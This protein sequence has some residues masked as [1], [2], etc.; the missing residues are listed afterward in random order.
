MIQRAPAVAVLLVA[1]GAA[2]APMWW[3]FGTLQLVVSL[4]VVVLVGT[5]IA[6]LAAVRRWSS[7]TIILTGLAALALLAVPLTAPQRI[8]R[9]EWLPA[10][11]D[12]AAA[13]VLSWRRLLTIG[14]PVGTGDS[15]LMAPVVLVLAGTIIGVS[16]ALRSR[17][18]ETAA[19][20][21]AAI[22]VWSILWGPRDL[23]DPW[24]S[25]LLALVPIGAYVAVV[26]QARR[27]VRAPRALSSLAR[28]IVAGS[29][30]AVVAAGAAGVAGALVPLP[31]RTVLRGDSPSSIEL[32][33]A[34][35]LAAYRSFW[36]AETRAAAQLTA[37]G[38]EPGDRIRTAVLESYDGEVLSVGRSP[39]ERVA[40]AEPGRGDVVGVTVDGLASQWLPVVGTPSAIRFVGERAERLAGGLHRNDALGTYVLEQGIRP[41]DGYQMLS[42]PGSEIVAPE[43]LAALEPE[44]PRQGSQALP[45]A[46]LTTL[47]A[48]TGEA[49]TPGERLSAMVAGLRADGYVS[50]GVLEDEV[51]SRP[52]HSLERLEALFA[53]PMIGDAEQYATAAMLLARQLGFDARVVVGFT[54]DGVEP[55]QPT[56]VLGSD[57]D[58]WIEVRAQSG[59]VGV[60]VTP[61]PRPIPEQED[62]SPSVVEEPPLQQ[63]PAPA[64][65]GQ[66]EGGDPAAP[67]A[68][69]DTDDSAARLLQ[70]L[71]AVGAVLGL[72]A[73][74]AAIPVGLV[75]AKV[76]RRRRRRRA[77]E[78]RDRAEGAWAEVVDGLRDRG[79]SLVPGGT[80]VEQAAGDA[81]MHELAHRVDRAVFA[82]QPPSE[83]EV[84]ATWAIGGAVLT[85]RDAGQGWL[86]PLLTRLNP[87]SLVRR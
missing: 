39:F 57:A 43:A 36:A 81:R 44:D 17:R 5:A 32:E 71:A 20:V 33:G 24:L 37:T 9:G 65:G 68:P 4:A 47:A 16:L 18:A 77:D 1:I 66:T 72:V 48:W 52:G 62:G 35:P 26:R 3:M 8:P 79:E 19:L 69:Q 61:E 15:L 63:A 29:L 80:R 60:D 64:P 7:I 75:I 12:A 50:H 42:Q 25:G 55:G 76:V 30:V 59:W 40:G 86:R 82:A 73:L 21:P 28:R 49:S 51:P 31:E 84:E 46:M 87:A 41:G 70:V 54:P 11:A 27:R 85:A 53:D 6:W 67:S 45:D 14:L 56:T 74:I 22:G 23:P 78:P 38:L 58:A 2:C 13:L 10:F 83:Q 34:S